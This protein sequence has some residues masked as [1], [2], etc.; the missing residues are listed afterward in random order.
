MN[1]QTIIIILLAFVAML[2]QAQRNQVS[3]RLEGTIGDST[4]NTKLLLY[5]EIS[6]MRMVNAVIDTV[7][8]VRG[9]IIPR[10]GTLDEA[11]TFHLESITKDDERPDIIS[12]EFIIEEGKI[13]IHFNQKAE[14]YKAPETPLN[15]AFGDFVNAFYPL[16]HGD[17][18]RQ[19]RL[20]SL[21][22]SELKRHYDDV[23][24]MQAL[25]MAFAHVNP[26]TMASWLELM[27][28]RIK[29]GEAWNEMKLALSAMGVEMESQEQFFS[30]TVGEKFV[31]FSVEYEGKTTRLSDYV[32]RCQYVLVD[33]WASWCGPCRMEIP[34]IIAAYNKYKDRGL[35]VVGIAAWDKPD[36]S[37][38]AIKEDGV[39]YP[40]ILN[41]QDIATKAYNLRGIPHII[42]F[43]P[44][45]TILAR[46]LRGKDIERTLA[47]YF[48]E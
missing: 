40:Q 24:G 26:S 23:L 27:S 31:D 17:S 3:Y 25:A 29:A 21:M 16:L 45:G 1:K 28:P 41:T 10:D 48:V 20:D 8:V 18:V 36:N 37:L 12:P 19:Q 44:D 22:Q 14:E 5:Q 46:G 47:K 6:P 15:K 38:Q 30:P 2:A 39:P 13:Y 43:S 33:F 32:G 4:L 11:G 35:Q 7:E 9:K 34:N 42:L